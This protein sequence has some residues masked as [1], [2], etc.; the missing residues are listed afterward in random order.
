MKKNLFYILSTVLLVVI[1]STISGVFGYKIGKQE[2]VYE[3]DSAV[4]G[5]EY[6]LRDKLSKEA[7]DKAQ[8]IVDEE[9]GTAEG[10]GQKAI[11]SFYELISEEK[12]EDAWELLSEDYQ[13]TFKSLNSFKYFYRNFKSI[14][15]KN[16]EFRTSSSLSEMDIATLDIT[17]EIPNS[18]QKDGEKSFYINT[19][20]E[21]DKWLIDEIS[22]K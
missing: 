13:K 17:Y 10:S 9:T 3:K 19:I 14:E 4:K 7:L 21:G 2:G 16:V 12:Y 1:A 15:V 20:S 22:E 6:D 5:I 11:K 18:T 8:E